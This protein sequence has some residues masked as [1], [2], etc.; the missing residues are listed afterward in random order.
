[1][2][3]LRNT[4]REALATQVA[5]ETA[6]EA[7]GATALLFRCKGLAAPY[8]A[9]FARD[10]RRELDAAML[11]TF[12]PQVRRDVGVV[13]VATQT[14]QQSLDIDADLLVTDLCPADVLLQRLGRLHRHA[15]ARRPLGFETPLA[16][17]LVPAA[18]DLGTFIGKSGEANG[19]CGFGFVYEDLRALEATWRLIAEL[20][21]VSVPRDCRLWVER[22]THPDALAAVA[23][24]LGA[25][26]G[27]HQ[28]S[29]TGKRSAQRVLAGH[30]LT[31]WDVA[32]G[33]PA[34]QFPDA[35]ETHVATRLGVSDRRAQFEDGVRGAFGT[36]LSEIAVP[37]WW[38]HGVAED[39]IPT[40]IVHDGDTLRFRMG[41]RPLR[42]S[43]LGLTRDDLVEEPREA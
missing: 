2:L 29:I 39:A 25:R 41:V 42:Y 35:L 16:H 19:P 15:D 27:D 9:R 26:W 3:V 7:G 20:G 12:R 5:L 38:M 24:S 13:V 43:R 17:V 23:A 33:D 32:F 22:T 4:V 10:D 21:G 31:R 36:T 1:V 30:Q 18:R 6:A 11:D 40:D 34:C 8:H 37:G 28:V 14:A